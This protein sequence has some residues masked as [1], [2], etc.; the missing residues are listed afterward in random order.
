MKLKFSLKKIQI[1]PINRNSSI[2]KNKRFDYCFDLV[3]NIQT[4][5]KKIVY[6]D[7]SG[8]NLHLNPIR[9]RAKVGLT[10]NLQVPTTPGKKL[11]SI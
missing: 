3:P 9:G 2:T 7:E 10:P 5:E 11:S 8:F 1:S 6:I 4:L